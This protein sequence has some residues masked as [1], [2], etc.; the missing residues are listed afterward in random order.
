MQR[1]LFG[2]LFVLIATIR[3]ISK[4]KSTEVTFLVFLMFK[5]KTKLQPYGIS[6]KLCILAIT[7]QKSLQS[8]QPFLRI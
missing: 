1:R 2:C 8:V 6:R 7:M 3:Q 4:Q 5:T